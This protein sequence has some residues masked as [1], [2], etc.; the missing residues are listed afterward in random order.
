MPDR[1][2][3]RKRSTKVA[4]P[5]SLA[6]CYILLAAVIL[7]FG[8]IRFRLRDIPLERDE[9]EY[10]YAG[11]LLLEGVPPYTLAYSMKLPGTYVAYALIMAMFGQTPAGIHLGFLI[12][13]SATTALVFFLARRIFDA[14]AGVVAAAS[15][16][17]L[18][19]SPYVLGLAGHATHFVVLATL[20]GTVLLLKAIQSSRIWTFFWSGLLFGLAFLMK[21]PGIFFVVFA[22]A[23]LI[24]S[25][26]EPEV[27]GRELRVRAAMFCW[28]SVLPFALTC[29]WLWRAGAFGRFWF[30]TSTYAR[31]YG[32]IQSLADARSAFWDSVPPV[33]GSALPIWIVATVGLISI[34]WNRRNANAIFFAAAFSVCSFL[35]VCPGFYFRG[36]YFI[37]M[38]PAVSLFAGAA[39]SFTS[40]K[41]ADRVKLRSFRFV[42][43]FVFVIAYGYVISQQWDYWFEMDAIAACRLVYGTNPFP[44][45]VQIADYLKTNASPSASIAVV[46]SEPEIYFYSRHHSATGYIYTYPLMEQQPYALTMQ[47]EMISEIEKARPEFLVYVNSAFSWLRKPGSP[48]LIFDWTQLYVANGYE[49]VGVVDTL[50]EETQYRWGGDAKGYSPRTPNHVKIFKRT[51]S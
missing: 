2:K 11:Q 28:G 17:L 49:L 26:W 30:W 32:T 3:P 50:D 15:Y 23:Y 24:K 36:H 38:L 48:N 1:K 25:Q 41:L 29:L 21:Q 42:P 5:V 16:A 46:G 43:I 19:T 20:A 12:V 10:A 8:L 9:G 27:S 22:G 40:K 6:P 13:S 35:A 4:G 31:Q 18:V 45:A 39:V 33:I 51:S 44:E 7:F 47:R 37:L 34:F 14:T